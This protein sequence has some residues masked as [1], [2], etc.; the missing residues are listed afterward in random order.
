MEQACLAGRRGEPGIFGAVHAA[1]SAR[2]WEDTRRN[3]DRAI[4]S[5]ARV[6]A[7][8]GS[9]P[10]L[11]HADCPEIGGQRGAEQ[12]RV[13]HC[14]VAVLAPGFAPRIA[15]DEALSAVL[16]P[17][18]EDGMAAHQFF[19]RTGQVEGAAFGDVLSLKGGVD[20]EPQHKGISRGETA[21]H[22]R[23][24]SRNAL[25]TERL[26]LGGDGVRPG[27]GFD[28]EF[29]GVVGPVG[30]GADALLGH[31]FDP[32]ADLGA[33]VRGDGVFGGSFVVVDEE[34]GGN[35]VGEALF[36]AVEFD[37]GANGIGGA[38][39]EVALVVNG[40][41]L[42]AE[43]D[44]GGQ[45]SQVFDACGEEMIAVVGEVWEPAVLGGDGRGIVWVW[46]FG[47]S[48]QPPRNTEVRR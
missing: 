33:G 16:V 7:G 42:G 13:G 3:P 48:W 31:G 44:L 24:G 39:A 18:R 45:G 4:S 30:F 1:G 27:R 41:A 8:G 19:A 40:G 10:L 14:E 46:A 29:A 37:G 36:E 26:V 22:L 15:D 28:G 21:P 32:V 5:G 35:E 11:H 25:V 34:A 20:A 2:V 43:V 23:E 17:D 6:P 12:V 47:L 9:P 38:G